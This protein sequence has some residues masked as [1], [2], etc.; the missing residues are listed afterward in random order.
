MCLYVRT[1]FPLL[2]V[3]VK[4]KI[5]VKKMKIFVSL[6]ILNWKMLKIYTYI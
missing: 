3:C 2:Y 4:K 1:S 5:T 6:D